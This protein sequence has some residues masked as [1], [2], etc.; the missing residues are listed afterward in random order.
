MCACVGVRVSV[1]VCAGVGVCDPKP[2]QLR[3][4]TEPVGCVRA[5]CARAAASAGERVAAALWN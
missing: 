3:D 1:C 2:K 5:F 4:L